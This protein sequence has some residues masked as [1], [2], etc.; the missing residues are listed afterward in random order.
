[1]L[2]Q[3]IEFRQAVHSSSLWLTL[4]H[5]RFSLCLPVILG[6]EYEATE[7]GDVV[8]NTSDWLARGWYV[9]HIIEE[10]LSSAMLVVYTYPC[11]L[12]NDRI[13]VN[14]RFSARTTSHDRQT[15]VQHI[16]WLCRNSNIDGINL[17]SSDTVEHSLRFLSRLYHLKWHWYM[18]PTGFS[19]SVRN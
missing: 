6:Y 19:A 12:Q 9:R 18:P 11:D 14:H 16:V 5:F 17:H 3:L 15:N 4:N 13:L 10:N 8:F 7:F 2:N 1:V